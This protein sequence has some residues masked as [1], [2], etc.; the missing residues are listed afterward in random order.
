MVYWLVAGGGLET[1]PDRFLKHRGCAKIRYPSPT[2][3]FPAKQTK[4]SVK[5]SP[6]SQ[7]TGQ[8]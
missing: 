7:E 2:Q 6:T 1:K 3:P 4:F 5:T 8:I